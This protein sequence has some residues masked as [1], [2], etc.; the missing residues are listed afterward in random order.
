MPFLLLSMSMSGGQAPV[1]PAGALTVHN[2]EVLTCLV[3]TQAIRP[4]TPFLYAGSTGIN[5]LKNVMAITGCPEA[6]LINCS[7][8]KLAYMYNLPSFVVGTYTDSKCPD[9]QASLEKEVIPSTPGTFFC[10][11]DLFRW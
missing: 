4:G 1:T 9:Q 11:M 3:L 7:V 2:A 6:A 8:A 10:N 5:Y